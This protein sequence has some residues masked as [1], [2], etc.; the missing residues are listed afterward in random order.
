MRIGEKE[1]DNKLVELKK[2]LMRFRTQLSTGVAP[3]NPGK[4]R[5]IK[6]TIARINTR[7]ISIGGEK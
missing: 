5:A 6:K 7:L 1:L 2:E 4:G 3:E